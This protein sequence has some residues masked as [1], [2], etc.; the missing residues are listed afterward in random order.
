MMVEELKR[1]DS[2]PVP[3]QM[4]AYTRKKVLFQPYAN[5]DEVRTILTDEELLELHLFNKEKEYRC[6]VSDSKVYPEG[7]IEYIAEFEESHENVY[8]DE[9]LLENGGKITV[10]NHISFNDENGMAMIDD[11][12]LIMGGDEN[13]R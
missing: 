8:R 6:I 3:G 9:C 5:T 2:A 12:R 13:G 7:L 4:L 11:Y 10:L 1:I